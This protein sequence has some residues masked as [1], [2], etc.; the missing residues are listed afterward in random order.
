MDWVPEGQI[1]K[2]VYYKEV[3]TK[4]REQMRRRKPEMGSL[5]RQHTS[6][7]RPVFQ[8]FLK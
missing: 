3:L 7:Q 2:Q 4:L 8:D 6:T 1:A 5:L